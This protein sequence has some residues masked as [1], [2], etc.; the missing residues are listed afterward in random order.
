[1]STPRRV[2]ATKW[3]EFMRN[4]LKILAVSAVALVPVASLA[5]EPT[6]ETVVAT[7]DGQDITLGHM[8]ILYSNLPDQ[9][10]Q[11]PVSQMFDAILD[12]LIQQTAL[13]KSLKGDVPAAVRLSIENERRALMA[14]VEISRALEDAVSEAD[15]EA[16]YQKNYADAEGAREFNASHI[17]VETEEE[18]AAIRDSILGGADFAETAKE[19][20]TGPSGP[21]GGELGWFG[22]GQMVAPF[23]SAVMAMEK[24][25]VS[26][27]VQTQFGWHVI[28]LNDARTAEAPTLDQVRGQI[29]NELESAALEAHVDAA[30][31]SMVVERPDISDIDPEILRQTDL[32]DD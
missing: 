4:A 9:Y 27:P 24:G 12:Q 6:A 29:A 28:K 19:K 23:E 15:I 30:V 7:V 16:A 22:E 2:A 25:D 21:R 13:A 17:L 11:V 10:K 31:A 3:N 18:A 26:E 1:M 20:S 5:A 8:L 32:L 14:S